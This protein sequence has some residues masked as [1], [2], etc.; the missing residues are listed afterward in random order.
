MNQL[1]DQGTTT[2]FTPSTSGDGEQTEQ[3]Q[4]GADGRYISWKAAWRNNLWIV[5]LEKNVSETLPCVCLP[6]E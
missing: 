4:D 2:H 3:V 5:S 1:P 6:W